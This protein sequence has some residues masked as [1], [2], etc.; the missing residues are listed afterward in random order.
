MTVAG[1]SGSSFGLGL[2][3]LGVGLLMAFGA[4]LTL[5]SIWGQPTS[6]ERADGGTGVPYRS[7]RVGEMRP[8]FRLLISVDFGCLAITSAVLLFIGFAIIF[9]AL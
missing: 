3:V 2:L 1:A 6:S 4:A 7:A 5:R 9:R 8:R